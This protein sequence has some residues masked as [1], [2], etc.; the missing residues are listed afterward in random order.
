MSEQGTGPEG[1]DGAGSDE[2]AGE[3]IAEA[4]LA[5]EPAPAVA[6]EALD[7]ARAVTAFQTTLPFATTAVTATVAAAG[8]TPE[9]PAAVAAPA[10]PERV[11]RE[12]ATGAAAVGQEAIAP[13]AVEREAAPARATI[14]PPIAAPA[15]TT[16]IAPPAATTPIAPVTPVELPKAE[17]EQLIAGAGLQW[18]ETVARPAAQQEPAEIP[19]PRTPRVRRP[20]STSAAEPLQQV[21]T[22]P[23]TRPGSEG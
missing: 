5:G 22:Q 11:A 14:A 1:T 7:E 10:A 8:P 16:P 19:A 17:L 12:V 18:V 4:Q 2:V 21:E 3:P 15:A 9:A 6:E 23:E 20:R 13:D